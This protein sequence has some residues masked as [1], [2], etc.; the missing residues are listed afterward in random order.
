[1]TLMLKEWAFSPGRGA[2]G[3]RKPT[4]AR[5]SGETVRL[6]G[7]HRPVASSL[8]LRDGG[9]TRT[10]AHLLPP[11]LPATTRALLQDV[12]LVLALVLPLALPASPRRRLR[13]RH[14]SASPGRCP[15]RKPSLR[16]RLT[17]PS[18]RQPNL[19]PNGAAAASPPQ[20]RE[21]GGAGSQ[22]TRGRSRPAPPEPPL[23][24]RCWS[25]AQPRVTEPRPGLAPSSQTTPA[26]PKAPPR[27]DAPLKGS[28]HSCEA[29]LRI[30]RQL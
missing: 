9:V 16:S 2:K 11:L 15:P 21:L 23:R 19:E 14:G 12:A 26:P 3:V 18:A 22:R 8:R 27:R 4:E 6:P 20:L 17:W 30:R 13:G 10:R 1:M 25:V 29:S 7:S 28:T 5:A 24:G